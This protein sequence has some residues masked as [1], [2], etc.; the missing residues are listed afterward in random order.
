M[1]RLSTRSFASRLVPS[2]PSGPLRPCRGSCQRRSMAS[3]ALQGD[4]TT[5][6]QEWKKIL[7]P[8]QFRI[9]RGKGTVSE[10][11]GAVGGRPT[12]GVTVTLLHPSRIDALPR[13]RRGAGSTTSTSSLT[14]FTSVQAAEPPCTSEWAGGDVPAA[15]PSNHVPPSNTPAPQVRYLQ[16]VPTPAPTPQVR[17]QI[18]QWMRMAGVLCRDRGRG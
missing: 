4:K 14:A 12:G 7:S 6:D 2:P 5:S 18:Q 15:G 8:E 17:H 10:G 3:Q 13:S 1:S 16:I 9:L 11:G